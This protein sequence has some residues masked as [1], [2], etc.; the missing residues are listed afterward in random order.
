M[1]D[2]LSSRHRQQAAK[3]AA[4][5]L[6]GGYGQPSASEIKI[7]FQPLEQALKSRMDLLP[8]FIEILELENEVSEEFLQDLAESDFAILMTLL[9]AA[10]L[11]DSRV[12]N[13]LGY[14]GQQALTPNR[15]GFGAEELV[16][17]LL[18][19]PKRFRSV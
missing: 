17:E 13:S 6:P 9:C 4:L 1:K 19:K 12:K 2:L 8:R 5:A 15:G 11:M 10:Y 14:D 16:M 3:I 7:E 18:E